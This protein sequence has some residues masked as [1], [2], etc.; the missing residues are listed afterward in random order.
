MII[1]EFK[2]AFS[3]F[4]NQNDGKIAF[5][6]VGVVLRSLGQNPSETD[7][8]KCC[9]EMK[10]EDRMTFDEFLPILRTVLI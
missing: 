6:Q 7:I 4:H 5:S 8:Q 10:P 3:L 9:N 2:E 1:I